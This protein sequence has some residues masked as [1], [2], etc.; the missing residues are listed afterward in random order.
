MKID[1]DWLARAA[2]AAYQKLSGKPLSELGQRYFRAGFEQGFKEGIAEVSRQALR[3][4]LELRNM[5]LSLGQGKL[6]ECCQDPQVLEAWIDKAL[7]VTAK[8]PEDIFG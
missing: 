1:A 3:A 6:V 5:P 7:T 8:T 4:V 2:D